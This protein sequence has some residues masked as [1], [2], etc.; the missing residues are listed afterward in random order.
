MK[1]IFIITL[2]AILSCSAFS[3]EVISEILYGG[4]L[5][6]KCHRDVTH[7][8]VLGKIDARTFKFIRD[9]LPDLTYLNLS[10][11]RI[12]SYKVKEKR[13]NWGEVF[14][15]TIHYKANELPDVAFY[16]PP[17]DVGNRYLKKV[18][19][20]KSLVAIGI[21]AF[22]EVLIDSIVI[23]PGVKHIGDRAFSGCD[24][25]VFIKLPENIESIGEEA[26][27]GC[28][29]LTSM[30]LHD[31]IEKIGY[32]TFGRCSN[33]ISI[34]L[35][36]SLKS[37]E[38]RAFEFCTSLISVEL[39]DYIEII[40]DRTFNGCSKL[41]SIKLPESLKK[42]ES[43]AFMDCHA[44]TSIELPEGVEVIGDGAF[45]DCRALT[46]IELPSSVKT[47]GRHVFSPYL[48]K[49]SVYWQEPWL[50]QVS[51]DAFGGNIGTTI[52]EVPF[53]T[54]TEYWN[55]KPWSDFMLAG[56][57]IEEREQNNENK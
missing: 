48:N 9:S 30:E 23:P 53:G 27:F 5:L 38:S 37:I 44:L 35:P 50:I 39:P 45:V 4:K 22:A 2:L 19:L 46:S 17:W 34:K 21:A 25:L 3:Q 54:K 33:L 8:T 42:I 1:K 36:K 6:R 41:T 47:I 40:K 18:I 26:F 10:K 43:L 57:N 13:T 52:L 7:L 31:A 14:I 29:S 16:S 32:N 49:I 12:V 56:D 20:P 51:P 11:T 15:N 24:K 55:L 28:F